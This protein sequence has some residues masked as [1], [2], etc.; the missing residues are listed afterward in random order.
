MV[1]QVAKNIYRIGVVLPKN[2]LKELNS[3]FIR[4]DKSDLLI[5][6]GFRCDECRAALEQGLEELGSDAS[7]RDVLLTHIHSDHSGMAD[8]FVGAGRKIYMSEIDLAYMRRFLAGE[9][10]KL[11]RSRFITEGF[12]KEM[13]D[14]I[15]ANN[16]A[17]QMALKEISDDFVGFKDGDTF[18]VGEYTLKAIIVPGHT[19]GNS[20]F[21]IENQGIM[22]SGD[23]ILFDITPNITEWAKVEDSLGD[24]IESLKRSKE[25]DVKLTLPGHRK[26]GNYAERIDEL[27]SH[28]EAR[29]AEALG[30][31]RE[32]P[33]MTAYDIAG[34]M[35]WKIRASCWEDFP[36]VQKRFAV[37]ECISHLDHLMKRD[38]ITKEFSNG[39][40]RYYPVK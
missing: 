15:Y 18:T 33:G 16:P 29:I 7:R 34:K 23:H 27:L 10:E 6:T 2:P 36:I 40:W 28:H 25:Y 1:E 37:G 30:I 5:D 22:F 4:G 32:F 39:H 14:V 35:T 12:T 9:T 24:Y 26:T 11:R 38:K 17:V 31:V 13:I 19:P 8:I 20:M 3:Y 21:Y